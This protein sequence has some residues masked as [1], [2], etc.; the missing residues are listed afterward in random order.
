MR[1]NMSVTAKMRLKAPLGQVLAVL[2]DLKNIA[3][4][5]PKIH[6]VSVQMTTETEGSYQTKGTFWGIPWEGSFDLKLNKNGFQAKMTKGFLAG[7]IKGGFHARQIDPETTEITHTEQCSFPLW[8]LPLVPFIRRS[9]F[10]G[11]FKEMKAL[12]NLINSI[13]QE[14][15]AVSSKTYWSKT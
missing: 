3:I 10:K 9:I 1:R 14:N 2:W 13:S 5:E 4:Y 7:Y 12:K 6:A 8:M 11:A 15:I